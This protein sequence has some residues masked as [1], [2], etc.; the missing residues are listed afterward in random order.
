MGNRTDVHTPHRSSITAV[1]EPIVDEA[2]ARRTGPAAQR[3]AGVAALLAASTFAFGFVMLVTVL[4]DYSIGDPSPRASVAF[5][6]EHQTAL[7]VWQLTILIVFGVLLVPLVSGVHEQLRVAAP[8]SARIATVFGFIWAGLVIAAGM[9][10]NLGLSVV[11][12][13]HDTAPRQAE[14][15][16]SALDAVQTGLGGG[17]EVVGGIWVLVVSGIALRAAVWSRGLSL[18]GIA[19]GLAGAVTIVPAF[20]PVGAVFGLGLVVWFVWLGVVLLRSGATSE[21]RAGDAP[22]LR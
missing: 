22:V 5:L 7:F 2:N 6:V 14:S 16:W 20:E 3:V 17:N 15:V 8:T 19:A 10:A 9:I 13:L 18:L 21:H 1:A 11:S 12:D 4:S